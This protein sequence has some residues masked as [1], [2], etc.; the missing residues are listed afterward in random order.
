MP[1]QDSGQIQD[2]GENIKSAEIWAST[3]RISPGANGRVCVWVYNSP[4]NG[5]CVK[6]LCGPRSTLIQVASVRKNRTAAPHLY[7]KWRYISGRLAGLKKD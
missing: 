2:K 3:R 7:V 1:F 5:N 4:G 6:D